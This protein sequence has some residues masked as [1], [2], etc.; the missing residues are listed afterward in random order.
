MDLGES[1]KPGPMGPP[2]PN[3]YHGPRGEVGPWGPP[4]EPGQPA[5][6]CPSD[7]GVSQ[8]LAPSIAP[9]EKNHQEV[10][11]PEETVNTAPKEAVIQSQEYV[12]R[13]LH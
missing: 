12:V 4:G 6:Y 9:T 13:H 5:S 3:G 2:G 10:F 1:G 11:E 7:C 8:I